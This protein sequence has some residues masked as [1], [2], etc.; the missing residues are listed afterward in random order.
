MCLELVIV[1]LPQ[2]L[3]ELL[4]LARLIH[5][6]TVVAKALSSPR[7][8]PLVQYT[9]VPMTLEAHVLDALR[10][11]T[12]S[13]TGR[14]FASAYQIFARLPAPLQASLVTRHGFPG[15]GSGKHYSAASA[16]AAVLRRRRDIVE[17]QHLDTNGV[18]YSALGKTFIAGCPVC[19]LYRL[20]RRAGSPPAAP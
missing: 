9:R 4:K 10:Q 7:S 2:Q 1:Q 13:S 16:V 15:K 12:E 6:S 19:G 3:Q 5:Q 20:G 18:T 14:A 17:V 11:L 8:P